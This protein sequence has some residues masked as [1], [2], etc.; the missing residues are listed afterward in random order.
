MPEPGTEPDRVVLHEP[1][2]PQEAAILEAKLT[3]AG[4]EAVVESAVESEGVGGYRVLVSASDVE[5]GRRIVEGL[6][7]ELAAD[8]DE[9]EDD[10]PTYEAWATRSALRFGLAA[11]LAVLALGLLARL[12]CRLF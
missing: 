5:A 2:D 7:Q 4:I 10:R 9:P 8:R 3:D 1:V 11:F 12:L 6:C